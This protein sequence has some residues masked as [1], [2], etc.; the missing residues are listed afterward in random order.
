V[1]GPIVLIL[2]TVMGHVQSGTEQYSFLRNKGSKE[3]R[4][5]NAENSLIK[6]TGESPRS[7]SCWLD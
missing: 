4:R 1:N 6:K 3:E 2:K 5:V 7:I